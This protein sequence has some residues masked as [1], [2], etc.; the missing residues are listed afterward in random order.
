MS[1][2]QAISGAPP[3][4]SD[5]TRPWWD[6]LARGEVQVQ[7][8][9]ACAQW[10]FYPRPF[11]PACG[12]RE[13]TWRPVDGRATLYTWSVARMP[14]SSAFAHL[15]VP[16]MAVAELSIGVRLPTTLV[17]VSPEDV[18]IGMALEPV[19]DAE[20]YPDATLLRYRPA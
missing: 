9:D 12:L 15:D 5:V 18:R 14:V 19:F 11:C 16:I 10:V 13:L 4:I 1:E 3:L 20:A 8:C 6:A 2:A 7:Q 17:G